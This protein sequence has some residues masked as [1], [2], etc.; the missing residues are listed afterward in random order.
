[1]EPKRVPSAEWPPGVCFMCGRSYGEMIDTNVV[2]PG[3]GRFYICLWVCA[4]KIAALLGEIDQP[5]PK[6]SAVK[7]NGEP[8]TADALPGRQV[9]VAHL[10]VQQQKEEEDAVVAAH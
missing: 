3:D 1:M 2:I 10:R 7:A 6:C 9:C 5:K 4:P 8:C